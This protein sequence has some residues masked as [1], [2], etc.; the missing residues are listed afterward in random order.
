VLH[1]TAARHDR[2]SAKQLID[3]IN[4][5][6][7]GV[8]MTLKPVRS[9]EL[10]TAAGEGGLFRSILLTLAVLVVG[11]AAASV[12]NLL[13]AI[14]LERAHE[15]AVLRSLGV[16]RRQAVWLMTTEAGCYG[17]V[18]AVVGA[19]LAVPLA[20][21]LAGRLADHF[22]HLS[23]DRG[24]EQ[25][26]LA[27]TVRPSTVAVGVLLMVGVVMLTARAAARRVLARDLDSV[28]RGDL[29]RQPPA[30]SGLVRPAVG[31]AAGAY[32]LGAASSSGAGGTLLYIGVTVLLAAWW[33]LV[34]RGRPDRE[35]VDR[36]A[37]MAGLVWAFAGSALLGD[38]SQGVQAGFGVITVAGELAIVCACVLLSSRLRSVM[39]RVRFYAP[40]G[41]PQVALLAAGANAEESRDRSGLAMGTVAAALF[42]VA[43]LT[44]LGNASGEPVSRQGGGFD[45]VATSVADAGV[46]SLRSLPEAGTV[47]GV[48]SAVQPE[49]RYR[50]EDESERRMT[51]PYPVRLAAVDAE[52]VAAQRFRVADALPGY[53]TATQALQA[54]LND[55]DKAVLD[56]YSRPEGAHPGDDVVLDTP[57]GVRRFRLI[58]VLDTFLLNTVF[59]SDT[60]FG[61]ATTRR[62]DTLVLARAAPGVARPA[63][64]QALLRAGRD[65]G[66]APKTVDESRRD[67]IAVNRTFTD[68]FAVLLLLSLLVAITSLAAGVVRNARERRRELGVLRAL[69]MGRRHVALLLAAEPVLAATLGA[70]VGLGVGLLL[71]RVLFAVGFSDLPFLIDWGR[72]A[73][74]VLAVEALLCITCWLAAWPASRR[75]LEA[76]LADAG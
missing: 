8:G 40:G 29:L 14:G 21:A 10:N 55:A 71:L 51:V 30:P 31:L 3:R 43:A 34:R 39:R 32:C 15:L 67:V 44:V 9:D 57:S 59:L 74:V 52:L 69:G 72:L 50:V 65:V 38:F 42:A 20:G 58:A 56:R 73:L 49:Q 35:V 4:A 36:R 54:V 53:G 5:T 70:T 11:A 45:V 16:S 60:S 41:Q 26:E 6:A 2:A 27:L 68:L 12:V 75:D 47:V 13:T 61:A 62:G 63:L 7:V 46:E 33:L 64:K 48:P 1:L 24:R 22:A 17:V 37:A 18:A 23:A 28:L 66:L 25:V 19:T 76:D